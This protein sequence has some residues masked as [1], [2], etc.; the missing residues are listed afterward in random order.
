MP[1]YEKVPVHCSYFSKANKEW[2]EA[3]VT[4]LGWKLYFIW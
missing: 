1:K 2:F 3:E 4:R